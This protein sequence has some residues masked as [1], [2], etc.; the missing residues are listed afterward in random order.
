M[1]GEK[2]ESRILSFSQ[3]EYLHTYTEY[4]LNLMFCLTFSLVTNIEHVIFVTSFFSHFY[5]LTHR[6]CFNLHERKKKQTFF[7][8]KTPR[9]VSFY[10]WFDFPSLPTHVEIQNRTLTWNIFLFCSKIFDNNNKLFNI[11]KNRGKKI[12]I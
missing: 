1:I 6:R 8:Q 7:Q 9:V 10:F 11:S 12:G 2:K 4:P 3:D 5:F